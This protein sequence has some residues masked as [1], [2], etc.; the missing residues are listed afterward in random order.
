MQ[1]R[2]FWA[3]QDIGIFQCLIHRFRTEKERDDFVSQDRGTFGSLKA[4]DPEVRRIQRRIAAGE[5]VQF[6]V[7]VTT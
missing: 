1:K 5:D 3:A 4:T 2:F 7:E 6:P